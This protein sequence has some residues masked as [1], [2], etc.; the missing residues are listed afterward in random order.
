M[1]AIG[2]FHLSN[3]PPYTCLAGITPFEYS[4]GSSIKGKTKLHPYANKHLK[5][6]LN[7]AAMGAVQLKGEYK[8]YYQRRTL[9][10]KNKMST[11]NIIRNKLVT[12][13]FA[14]V[15]RQT[16]YVDFSTFAA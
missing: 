14:V 13:V 3:E 6:L 4:S 11:L 15:K 12:R 10:G 5:S 7:I 1:I 16:P 8:T 9:E 2:K